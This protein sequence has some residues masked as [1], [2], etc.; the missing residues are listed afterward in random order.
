[1]DDDEPYFGVGGH[2]GQSSAAF[3][4]SVLNSDEIDSMT[5]ESIK[6]QLTPLPDG[7]VSEMHA[8]AGMRDWRRQ[9]MRHDLSQRDE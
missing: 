6:A 4:A 9:T 5:I 7:Q 3:L 2:A 8:A 1:L